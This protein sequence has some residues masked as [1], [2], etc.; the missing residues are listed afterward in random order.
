[1]KNIIALVL[2][3]VLIAGCMQSSI[4][5]DTLSRTENQFS[6]EE[7]LVSYLSNTQLRNS[8]MIRQSIGRDDI[9]VAVSAPM[10]GSLEGTGQNDFSSTNVQVVG[11]DEAD[12]IKTDGD[13]IYTVSGNTLFIISAYPGESASVISKT[14]F[15]SYPSELFINEDNLIIFSTNYSRGST[16]TLIDIY[17]ISNK[18]SINKIKE[19]EFEGSYFKSRM[20]DKDI[21]IVTTQRPSMDRP[22]PFVRVDAREDVIPLGR[23]FYYPA[24]SPMYVNIHSFD[25]AS[26]N[27]E[28]IA[29]LTEGTEQLYMSENA[30][31]ISY[32]EYISEYDIYRRVL[33]EIVEP[34]LSPEEKDKIA[35][36]NAVD[37]DILP[38]YEKDGKR[39]QIFNNYL[40]SLPQADRVALEKDVDV[41]VADIMNQYDSFQ[42][43]QIHKIG[44][45][46]LAPIANGK[47]PGRII[48]Q[49]AL[50]EHADVLR[51]ATTTGGNWVLGKREETLNNVY[52]LDNT[53]KIIGSLEGLA[54]GESIF[55]TRF[56]ED[57]LYMVTFEQIDPFFVIN[58]SDPRDI[59]NLGELKIPG[60][61]RY[62]HPYDENIIIGLGQDATQ[63]GRVTGLK[64]SLFDVSDVRNPIELTNYAGTSQYADSTA[65]YEHRAFLF[66]KEKDLLVIPVASYELGSSYSGAFVFK[67]RPDEITLR[68]LVEHSNQVERSLY[69]EE[70]LYTKSYDM[71]AINQIE[72]LQR[73]KTLTLSQEKEIPVY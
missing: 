56:I 1:M 5:P 71:I 55:S 30:L 22:M 20:M 65:L 37:A 26:F 42:N 58:L 34:K 48:N 18:V 47:V 45:K 69:I 41:R 62:L 66:S 70:L 46:P 33:A 52:T 32:T 61:S 57:R 12:I 16:F 9:A 35:R 27:L 14:R 10:S 53:L 73:V 31:Y 59:Q 24:N 25:L 40:Y 6:S 50:D 17:D 8:G 7:E 43:T 54:K 28:S 13:Y 44:L 15:E 4:T 3:I 67:I 72:D 38:A 51:I 29:I 2:S 11:I 36:I 68:G 64:I 23:I 19:F 49:F 39:N 21:Y 63:Q 60:F